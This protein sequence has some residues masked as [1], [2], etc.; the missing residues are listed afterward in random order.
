MKFDE[1]F[2]TPNQAIKLRELGYNE[3]CVAAY[4]K[5]SYELKSMADSIEGL[6]KG[7]S[8]YKNAKLGDWYCTYIC[9]APMNDDVLE[10]FRE[11]NLIGIVLPHI[12]QTFYF[13]THS[14]GSG[15][16]IDNLSKRFSSYKKAQKACIDYLIKKMSKNDRTRNK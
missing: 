13:I 11:R 7:E 10:W 15:V 14:D 4:E 1:K 16:K 8:P 12:D 6:L 5:D 9:M 2:V 3:P